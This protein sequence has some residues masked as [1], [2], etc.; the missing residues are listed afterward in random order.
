MHSHP[1]DFSL[2]RG[3]AGREIIHRAHRGT[4]LHGRGSIQE[5]P[6]TMP[7]QFHSKYF[8][9]NFCEL[10]SYTAPHASS[11]GNKAEPG[12]SFWVE[13]QESV[14]IKVFLIGKDIRHFM[15]ITDAVDNIPALGDLVSLPK[16]IKAQGLTN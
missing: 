5:L 14:R 9:E 10:F 13:H 12:G 6:V 8:E 7:R 11:E 2:K 3:E 15:R 1:S 4:G 16:I